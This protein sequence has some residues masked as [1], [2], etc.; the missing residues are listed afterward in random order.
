MHK[1]LN[2]SLTL[3]L[4]VG[5]VAVAQADSGAAAMSNTQSPAISAS[6]MPCD[7]LIAGCP[8][9]YERKQLRGVHIPVTM[10]AGELD[11]PG[12]NHQPG[13]DNTIYPEG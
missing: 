7:P 1:I 13:G 4:L 10:H 5:A 3:G 12:L 6:V 8:K 9:A 11:D 2:L